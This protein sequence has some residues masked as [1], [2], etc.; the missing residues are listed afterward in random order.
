MLIC[1][2]VYLDKLPLINLANGFIALWN[3]DFGVFQ[4]SELLILEPLNKLF[5]FF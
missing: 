4:N 5:I 2:K 3:D 1:H